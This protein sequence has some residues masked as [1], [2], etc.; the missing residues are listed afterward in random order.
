MAALVVI[1]CLVVVA[2]HQ[3]RAT[4]QVGSQPQQVVDDGV[5]AHGA[6]VPAVLDRQPNPRARQAC[7]GR[8]RAAPLSRR[9]QMG[10]LACQL[11][12]AAG[13]PMITLCQ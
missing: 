7:I 10:G 2:P 11:T 8:E 9:P 1:T 6:V 3:R 5:S 4:R 13:E 12:N